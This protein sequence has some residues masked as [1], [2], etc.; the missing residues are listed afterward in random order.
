MIIIS[1]YYDTQKIII[2]F[3]LSI[4]LTSMLFRPSY[5]PS[6]SVW[7]LCSLCSMSRTSGGLFSGKYSRHCL[8]ISARGWF[9]PSGIF[10][11]SCSKYFSRRST[12]VRGLSILEAGS[13]K[14]A[15]R[16]FSGNTYKFKAQQ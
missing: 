13:R 12:S 14:L 11:S 15:L 3:C 6:E 16:S 7:M 5:R 4:A 1:N 9:P 2:T 8:A 10:S